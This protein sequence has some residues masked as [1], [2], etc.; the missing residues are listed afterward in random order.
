MSFVDPDNSLSYEQW[1]ND[2][3][4]AV[5]RMSRGWQAQFQSRCDQ[6]GM[7]VKADGPGVSWAVQWTYDHYGTPEL[8]DA[9]HRCSPCTDRHGMK[10][11]NCNER[12][13]KYH[14]RNELSP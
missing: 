14:G 6:C 1:M 11:T 2:Q 8:C 10:A 7:F 9:T 5:P 4:T 13:G 3:A 12:D